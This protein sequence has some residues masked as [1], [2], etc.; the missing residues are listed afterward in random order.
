VSLGF[1][2][3][4]AIL[5]NGTLLA[6]GSNQA[7]QLGVPDDSPGM[8]VHSHSEISFCPTPRALDFSSE[9]GLVRVTSASAGF[10]HSACVLEDGR[11]FVWGANYDGQL[12][13]AAAN[14]G[15][16]GEGGEEQGEWGDRGLE[17]SVKDWEV[18]EGEH[19][20]VVPPL[21]L[22]FENA[23][24][25]DDWGTAIDEGN[26]AEENSPHVDDGGT[27]IDAEN[28][29][30]AMRA[31]AARQGFD[32]G[33]YEIEPTTEVEHMFPLD[34]VMFHRD[35]NP[36]VQRLPSIRQVW[37]QDELLPRL[38]LSQVEWR[39]ITE[40][41]AEEFQMPYPQQYR[42]GYG[43]ANPS[44]ES[45]QK[46]LD[47]LR[48]I[49]EESA[50][51]KDLES[52]I[53]DFE[54]QECYR[55]AALAEDDFNK[56]LARG[57]F[58][59]ARV[60][61]RKTRR[62][63]KLAGHETEGQAK[64]EMLLKSVNEA[65]KAAAKKARDEYIAEEERDDPD[66]R[67][68]NRTTLEWERP[69]LMHAPID[70]DTIEHIP[71]GHIRLELLYGENVHQ[72]EAWLQKS[73]GDPGYIRLELLYGEDVHQLEAW[74]Q[75]SLGDP[76]L[77]LEVLY[78]ETVH[79]LEALLQEMLQDSGAVITTRE[80]GGPV[81]MEAGAKG[82]DLST[83][84]WLEEGGLRDPTDTVLDVAS[85]GWNAFQRKGGEASGVLRVESVNPRFGGTEGE[86]GR[87][88]VSLFR[89]GKEVWDLPGGYE[90]F[91]AKHRSI[92]ALSITLRYRG[93]APLE[94]PLTPKE[95]A[96][97][98]K[99]DEF[100]DDVCRQQIAWIEKFGFRNHSA[101]AAGC[102]DQLQESH[103]RLL[104]L[105][106][107]REESL[108]NLAIFFEDIRGDWESA[109]AAWRRYDPSEN[110]TALELRQ[111]NV[112]AD[113]MVVKK[114]PEEEHY[115]QALNDY[116]D[117]ELPEEM[118]ETAR[119]APHLIRCETW[120]AVDNVTEDIPQ[121]RYSWYGT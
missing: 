20:D 30:D 15:G 105:D 9:G 62:A 19:P 31:R 114:T 98:A 68:F 27:A 26:M 10:A 41:E 53:C 44:K 73:L 94:K 121:G 113:A 49:Y 85:E 87:V 102:A 32:V 86:Q 103:L 42:D 66:G 97:E 23:P 100:H 72:L 76:G 46:L 2:H 33:P 101:E 4:L 65:E 16:V 48:A 5:R 12:G 74:L 69:S 17:W 39:N 70:K 34:R 64:C 119:L 21:A 78:G 18:P 43:T 51:C 22:S 52:L 79:Q 58:A 77:S 111:M 104:A 90:Y 75:K 93:M 13:R 57:N 120:Q 38:N 112:Q 1:Y 89:N 56:S 81:K 88:T 40:E 8:R 7:G 117:E 37:V 108:H 82:P 95:K 99:I 29:T 55:T 116:I 54:L 28:I 84:K 24:H 107:E 118:R 3:S 60:W 109:A 25:V 11:V 36:Y 61:A 115:E 83:P 59:Q 50:L 67:V 35:S 110:V 47:D 71:S 63:L 6:W 80:N 96:K 91:D 45:V 106:P 92:I 14:P